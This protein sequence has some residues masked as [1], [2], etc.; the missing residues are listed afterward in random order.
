MRRRGVFRHHR[1]VTFEGRPAR[2]Y[3]AATRVVLDQPAYR[4]RRR[5]KDPG[6]R[7]IGGRP[8]RLRLVVSELRGVG[9]EVLAVWLLLSNVPGVSGA[10][11]ALWYYWRWGVEDF[12]KLL[13]SAGQ[14]L[15]A[16]LQRDA[17]A[18]FK[19]LLLAS[20]ACC[21]LWAAGRGC[22]VGGRRLRSLLVRLS[23]RQVR[24]EVGWTWPSLL[25]GLG[26]LVVLWEVLEQPELLRQ[27]QQLKDSFWH[28]RPPSRPVKPDV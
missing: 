24:A 6:R 9:G 7:R 20:M 25:A 26:V 18:I 2:Q 5:G 23:G 17:A 21:V 8:L 28:N 14:K 19:R 16:W 15:E 1:A 3:I 4:N 13:K 12:F 27:V 10:E 22:G 11:V